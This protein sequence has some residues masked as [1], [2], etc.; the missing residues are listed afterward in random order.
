MYR[1]KKNKDNKYEVKTN[2]KIVKVFDKYDDALLYCEKLNSGKIDINISKN[3]NKKKSNSKKSN[4]KTSKKKKKSSS[5]VGIVIVLII[6]IGILGFLYFTGNL[7]T[8]LSKFNGD[9]TPNN[10]TN[11]DNSYHTDGSVNENVIFDDFQIHFMMLGNDKAG[12]SIYIKAGDTDIIIDAGSEQSSV[13]TT[14]AYMNKYITDNKI[15][16][17]ILTHGDADHVS[18]F[19]DASSRKGILSSYQ[20]DTIIDNELTNKTTQVYKKYVTLRDSLVESGTTHWYA[21]DCFNNENGAKRDI[22][23]S[24]NVTMSILY[25]Y[26]YF[27]KSSD[28]NNY[29]VSTMFTYS[30]NGTNKY[31]MFTGDLELEGEE[32]LSSYYDGSSSDKTLP[33]VELFK[34]GHHGSKTS[35]NEC[36]LSLI[37]PKMCVVSCCCGTDEYTK[38][39]DNQ[40]PTQQFIT[41][42]SKYT[43]AVYITSTYQTLS[44][45][46]EKTQINTSGYKAMNGNVIISCS[47]DNLGL[48]ASNNLIKLKDTQW[49]NQDI[50]I[51][52]T[53]RKMRVWE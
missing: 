40:F 21:G 29:S 18:G 27:N 34:A 20:I 1:V 25:N 39:I 14:K 43:D 41:R 17:V 7:D 8:I 2:S 46:D 30:Y 51:N 12:D 6:I 45:N 31:F 23:L 32:K 48:W 36:L 13:D 53:T 28:E 35:S 37:K 33:Q 49:F 10:T 22:K 26:Y 52:G 42:I 44:Y 5:S 9:S 11:V 4:K 24:E 15:E 50:T 19:T 3:T 38:N 47:N 16:Y